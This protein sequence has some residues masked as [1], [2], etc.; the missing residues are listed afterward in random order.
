M[1][2]KFSSV[3]QVIKTYIRCIDYNRD[4]TYTVQHKPINIKISRFS[5]PVRTCSCSGHYQK[6]M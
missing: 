6:A 4:I 2:T 5:Q 3:R 1:Y